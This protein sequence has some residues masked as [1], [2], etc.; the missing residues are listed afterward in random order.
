VQLAEAAL[1][2]ALRSELERRLS[3]ILP[4]LLYCSIEENLRQLMN[5]ARRGGPRRR[6][7]SD[8]TGLYVEWEGGKRFYFNHQF[9]H[10]RY[11]WPD[12]LANIQRFLLGKYQDGEVR[13]EP[14]DVVLEAGANVGEFTTAAAATAGQVFAF[15][16]DPKTFGCLARNTAGLGNVHIFQAG[17]GDKEGVAELFISRANSDS[18]FLAPR[19]SGDPSVRVP[20]TTI[21]AFMAE[22][23]LD[24]IDFLKV[25]AEGF[26]PEILAGAGERLGRVAKVA[27][28][29]GPE[30]YG[31]DTF[32]E[33]ETVLREAGL[34]T[35]RR[36]EDWMLFAVNDGL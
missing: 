17:L 34:R 9:L 15:D 11:V 2:K 33:C 30:R 21:S 4:P 28:D 14:G 31:A 18:S 29:C 13:L 1:I 7:G 19:D 5:P 8:E 10:N 23:K 16:P 36:P 25:E 24:R 22:H 26:E 12:G 20:V 27:V 3:K 6:T 32:S 35:W